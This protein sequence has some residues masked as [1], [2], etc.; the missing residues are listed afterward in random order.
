MPPAA[1]LAAF[2]LAAFLLIVIPGPSVLFVVGR[3]LAL[4]R[5]G[6]LLSVLGNGLGMLPQ[7]AAVAAGVGVLLAESVV[8]FT[9]VKFV[10]AAYLVYLGVQ[11]IRHRG[12]GTV[13][14]ADARP[15]SAWRLLREGFVV[16]LTNPK[17]VVFLVAVLP[18]FVD[19]HAGAIPLQMAVLGLV[20]ILIGFASDSVW[21]LAAGSARAWFARSPRRMRGLT[22]TGGAMMIGLGGALTLTGAKS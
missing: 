8:L 4:G 5:R 11:A 1:N 22:A 10:G 17:T 21:A 6:G 3:S 19:F 20:F 13:G 9:I 12:E 7:V 16:G 15:A 18:Q 2:A 14:T